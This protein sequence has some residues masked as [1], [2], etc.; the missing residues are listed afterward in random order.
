[1]GET[2]A[3]MTRAGFSAVSIDSGASKFPDMPNA[4]TT[5]P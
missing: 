1:M 4:T 5:T 2:E 3:F